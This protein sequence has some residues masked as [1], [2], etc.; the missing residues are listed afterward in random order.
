MPS[1]V[2]KWFTLQMESGCRV[3]NAVDKVAHFMLGSTSDRRA[4]KIVQ[5]WRQ[6]DLKVKMSVIPIL[7]KLP[8]LY[9]FVLVKYKTYILRFYVP[10]NILLSLHKSFSNIV[11]KSTLAKK[12]YQPPMKT[13]NYIFCTFLQFTLWHAT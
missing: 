13:F 6:G 12:I 1:E 9:F 10:L 7:I 3:S 5:F 4:L 2:D 8:H 11:K